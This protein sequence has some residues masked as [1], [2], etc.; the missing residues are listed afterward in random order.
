MVKNEVDIVKDWV[1]YHTSIFGLKNVF[2]VDNM[3]TDGT[4]EVLKSLNVSVFRSNDYRK[5]GVYMTN[6]SKKFSNEVIVP[7][8]IDEFITVYDGRGA[9]SCELILPYFSILPK[10]AVYKMNYVQVQCSKDYSRATLE[11]TRGEFDDQ[12]SF[13]K[14]FFNTSLFKGNI[15]HGNHYKTNN[16]FLSRFVL[17]HYHNRNKSQIVK[18]TKDNIQGLGYDLNN[19]TQLQHIINHHGDGNHHVKNWLKMMDGTYEFPYSPYGNVD[20]TALAKKI[21]QL[22]TKT[23]VVGVVSRYNES[24]DWMLEHPFNQLK[25][26]VYNKGSNENFCK[27]NVVTVV[28]LPNIGRCDHT[29]LYYIVHNY[30]TLH[31]IVVFLPG[32]ID[33]AFKKEKAGRIVN[34]IVRTDRCA[35]VVNEWGDVRERF[36]DFTLDEWQ[37]IHN[38]NVTENDEKK[39]T[40]CALRPFG[41]WYDAHFGNLRTDF[42]GL[43][44]IFSVHANMVRRRS[45]AE[46]Q[47]LLDEVSVSSNPE[48]GHYLERGWGAVFGS[49]FDIV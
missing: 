30:H 38:A 17:V 7:I 24:L 21:L 10:A 26:I 44:G 1:V 18:K 5:K 11:A 35:F 2:V 34:H 39:L 43:H 25:Y 27:C 14:S 28:N 33:I 19:R 42:Y 47:S 4:Y 41:K 3:S 22:T 20:I 29:F 40:P 45:V 13:A 49:G 46:Y 23:N 8:D 37:C 15:D 36:A 32:S 12:G 6:F 9:V 48:V 16:Y 31:P